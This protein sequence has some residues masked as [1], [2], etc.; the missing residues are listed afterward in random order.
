MSKFITLKSLIAALARSFSTAQDELSWSQLA[1]LQTYFHDDLTPKTLNMKLPEPQ[2]DNQIASTSFKAPI[3]SLIPPK[4]L[5]ITEAKLTFHVGLGEISAEQESGLTLR[6]RFLDIGR[7]DKG[8]RV[9]SEVLPYELLVDPKSPE[10]QSGSIQISMKV[11]SD[12]QSE[13]FDRMLAKL[14]QLQGNWNPPKALATSPKQAS[15]PE[16]NQASSES[17]VQENPEQKPAGDAQKSKDKP[18]SSQETT[19]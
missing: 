1:A 5:A 14:A 6:Q 15:E 7:H 10:K 13:G 8:G 11:R 2:A 16:E 17:A 9:H 18:S 3:L 19:D 4:P 12:S